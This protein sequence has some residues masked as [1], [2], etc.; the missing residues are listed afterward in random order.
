MFEIPGKYTTAKIFANQLEE[1][2]MSQIIRM[3]NHLAFTK[4]IAIMPD[5]HAGSGAVIGFTMP[6]GDK[7][8]P[9]IIGVDIGCGVLAAEYPP[10]FLDNVS[11]PELD[12]MI[13]EKVPFGPNVNA[14]CN[15]I[16]LRN[17]AEFLCP[18]ASAKLRTF[19]AA[20]QRKW[21][22][23]VKKP[24]DLYS[25]KWLQNKCEQI[26]IE[27]HR[28]ICSLG[29]LGGGNHFI[30]VGESPQT[31]N[32][33][34]VVHS[35]SRQFGLKIAQYHQQRAGRDPLAYLEGEEAFE[36]LQDMLFAQC[37]AAVNRDL[38]LTAIMLP[39]LLKRSFKRISMIESVHNYVDFDRFIIRKGAIS[40][41]PGE[42]ILVP[43]NMRDG[44]LICEGKGNSEWNFS[45]PHGAG[46]ILSRGQ[47]KRELDLD[48]F[49]EQMAGIFSTSVCASTID[50]APDAYKAAQ[51][52]I[53]AIA[54]TAEIVDRVLPIMNLKDR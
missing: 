17:L 16:G 3:V 36:Y 8:I 49:K 12:E 26:G 4:P 46:R 44:T 50:E 22:P 43:L 45:A 11:L 41:L 51:D 6:M 33:W 7:I 23:P 47:A 54:P 38:I 28:V 48:V 35:G 5:C 31:R 14:E 39:L 25:L 27:Y 34:V 21:G 18:L 52:I 15:P 13:R 1:Y 42:M 32:I 10:D 40:S 20:Y 19:N 37:Y 9:N 2:A 30:E 53:D 24:M 29:T